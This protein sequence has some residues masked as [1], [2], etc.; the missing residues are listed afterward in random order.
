MTSKKP[1]GRNMFGINSYE[2][3]VSSLQQKGFNF[4]IDW[5]VKP[6]SRTVLMRHDIDFSVDDA[7]VM[8]EVEAKLNFR[9]TYF[10]MLSSNMYNLLSKR[11]R[12]VVNKIKEMGHKISLHFDPTAHDSLEDFLEEKRVFENAFKVNVNVVSIHR[13]G[14]FLEN[15]NVDLYGTKQTYQDR[16]F[17]EYKYL[18]D[19]GGRDV[20]SSVLDFASSSKEQT[21]HLLIHPVW[22]VRKLN[23]PTLTLNHWRQNYFDIITDEIRENCKTYE[24]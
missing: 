15:N 24:G 3:L 16:Y 21:L 13:P 8:A 23:T 2:F 11:N 12:V 10:F 6:N 14:K 4:S 20:S 7:L 5:D 9:S 19:S 1:Q 17:K 18:S 22:W